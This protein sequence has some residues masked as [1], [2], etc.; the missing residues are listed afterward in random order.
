MN[1]ELRHARAF[2]VLAEELHF[3]RAAERLYMTQPALSR[4]IAQIEQAVGLRLVN[5]TTR[6]VSLTAHG[7]AL[8]EDARAAVESFDGLVTHAVTLGQKARRTLRVG[9][10]IGTAL[11]LVP[12]IVRRFTE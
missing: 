3:G 1:L 2:V 10:Q 4:T 5:R 8:L 6:S 11:S 7:Q 9:H 12:E